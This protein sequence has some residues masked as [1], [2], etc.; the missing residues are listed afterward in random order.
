MNV[1]KVLLNNIISYYYICKTVI[2]VAKNKISILKVFKI[3]DATVYY[4]LDQNMRPPPSERVYQVRQ[5]ASNTIFSTNRTLI[6]HHIGREKNCN[7]VRGYAG[8][9]PRSIAQTRDRVHQMRIYTRINTKVI[10]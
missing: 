2:C 8:A 5:N 1:Q 3:L 4:E 9:S 6:D 7:A 10:R